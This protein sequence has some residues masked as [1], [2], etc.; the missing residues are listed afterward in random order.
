MTRHR[1]YLVFMLLIYHLYFSQSLKLSVNDLIKI[2]VNIS[3]SKESFSSCG[4]H[5]KYAGL[6]IKLFR[7]NKFTVFTGDFPIFVFDVDLRLMNLGNRLGLFFDALGF[8]HMS[9]L[10]FVGFFC[11]D[12]DRKTGKFLNRNFRLSANVALESCVRALPTVVLHPN[13]ASSRQ[14]VL[15]F[16]DSPIN[17]DFFENSN[18]AS[19]WENPKSPWN[20]IISRVQDA[21]RSCVNGYL[22]TLNKSITDIGISK[23]SFSYHKV[24]KH[25]APRVTDGTKT[26]NSLDLKGEGEEQLPMVP[27]VVVKL[28]CSDILVNDMRTAE[29]KPTYGFLNFNTYLQLIPRDQVRRIYIV[30]EPL[31]RGLYGKECGHISRALANFL[32]TSLNSVSRANDTELPGVEVFILRERPLETFAMFLYSKIVICAPSTFCF[33]AILANDTPGGRVYHATSSLIQVKDIRAHAPHFHWIEY[34]TLY[35]FITPDV[36]DVSQKEVSRKIV[37]I[38]NSPI[39]QA[40]NLYT[41]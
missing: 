24:L 15:D 16:L 17:K 31:D 34:P 37:Q 1:K 3:F 40:E 19:P 13:P 4:F 36:H 20:N 18:T 14:E 41:V 28:R 38:L 39:V 30:S 26:N 11:Q 8:A 29:A 32:Y 25:E 2:Q 9:G 21:T 6:Y 23:K 35:R 7:E 5:H 12:R 33:Y 10:H 27:D 22:H